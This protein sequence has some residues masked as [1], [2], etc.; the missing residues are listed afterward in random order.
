VTRAALE[1]YERALDL[2][3]AGKLSDAI[4]AARVAVSEDR[5]RAEPLHVLGALLLDAGDRDAAAAPL[6]Q[7][8]A[9]YRERLSARPEEAEAWLQL[10]CV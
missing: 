9:A 4:A 8:K 10:A 5:D 7:A 2:R 3:A 6:S 1:A